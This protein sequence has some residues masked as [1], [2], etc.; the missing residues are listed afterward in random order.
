MVSR[1]TFK[2]LGSDLAASL[3]TFYFTTEVFL[4]AHYMPKILSSVEVAT[5]EDVPQ[6]RFHRLNAAFIFV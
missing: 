5:K 6:R 2:S 4:M 1:S 3:N